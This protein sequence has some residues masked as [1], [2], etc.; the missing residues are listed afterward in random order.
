[1]TIDPDRLRREQDDIAVA[2]RTTAVRLLLEGDLSE[3]VRFMDMAARNGMSDDD[4]YDLLGDAVLNRLR[5]D[6]PVTS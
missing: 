6:P 5:G 2:A 4:A 1:M 3:A